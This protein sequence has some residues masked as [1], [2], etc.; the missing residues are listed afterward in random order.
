MVLNERSHSCCGADCST[1]LFKLWLIGPWYYARSSTGWVNGHRYPSSK[2]YPKPSPN[3]HCLAVTGTKVRRTNF[4]WASNL[5]IYMICGSPVITNSVYQKACPGVL[6]NIEFIT[7][8]EFNEGHIT[9]WLADIY[10]VSLCS[11]SHIVFTE[12][13]ILTV[14]CG[15]SK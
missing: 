6:S 5:P 12:E 9:H 2:F 10:I 11:V 13:P 3:L 7:A 15:V 4:I 14:A 1:A 8:H